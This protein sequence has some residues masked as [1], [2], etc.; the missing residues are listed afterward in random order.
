MSKKITLKVIACPLLDNRQGLKSEDRLC[1]IPETRALYLAAHPG[2]ICHPHGKC[3]VCAVLP[4]AVAEE[5]RRHA[6]KTRDEENERTRAAIRA[7]IESR[8]S[9]SQ[10]PTQKALP[11]NSRLPSMA[12]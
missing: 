10:T 4:E 2:R 9:A 11:V 6:Q 5:I 12:T 7:F 8:S 3:R 1:H